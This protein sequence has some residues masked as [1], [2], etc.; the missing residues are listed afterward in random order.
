M[1]EKQK[2]V[3]RDSDLRAQKIEVGDKFYTTINLSLDKIVSVL[4]NGDLNKALKGF[5]ILL[6]KFSDDGVQ[7]FEVLREEIQLFQKKFEKLDAE[8]KD[9]ESKKKHK[10]KVKW[11]FENYIVPKINYIVGSES[12]SAPSE[13][14][15]ANFDKDESKKQDQSGVRFWEIN[16]PTEEKNTDDLQVLKDFLHNEDFRN[17]DAET[18]R[19]IL[20]TLNAKKKQKKNWLSYKEVE[21]IPIELFYE[22]DQVW[23]LFS[24]GRFGISPQYQLWKSSEENFKVFTTKIGWWKRGYGLEDNYNKFQFDKSAPIGHLPTFWPLI[25]SGSGMLNNWERVYEN[26]IRKI[27]NFFKYE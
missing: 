4:F 23:M 17:A 6:E 26:I 24:E 9:F 20:K 8:N 18:G 7:S 21:D 22:I 2:N 1:N 14:I 15:W 11:E 13:Y 16:L 10:Q 25:Q 19:V 5:D 27:D 12:G 3:I